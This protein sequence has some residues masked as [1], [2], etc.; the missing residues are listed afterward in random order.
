MTLA[1]GNDR[2]PRSAGFTLIE[3]SIALFVLAVLVAFA[4]PSFLRAYNSQVLRE[5]ALTFSTTCQLARVQAVT[6]QRPAML[7]IDLERQVFWVVQT[8]KTEDGTEGEEQ[9]VK[10]VELPPRVRL[11]AAERADGEFRGEKRVEVTFYPNG[12]CDSLSVL[13]R[14][15]E[16]GGLAATLDPITGQAIPYAVK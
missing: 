7:R 1:I 5:T 9:T 6:Q 14:G 2:R 11:M 8:A 16:P 15:G 13:F 10:V 4:A 12:T 3:L